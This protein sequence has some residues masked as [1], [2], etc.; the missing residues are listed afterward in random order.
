MII[1]LNQDTCY[2]KGKTIY[3]AGQSEYFKNMANDCLIKKEE[4]R[5]LLK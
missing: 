5:A 1:A 2:R 3:S 4:S